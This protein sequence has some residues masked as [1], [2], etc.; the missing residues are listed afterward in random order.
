MALSIQDLA[1]SWPI[2]GHDRALQM[3]SRSIAWDRVSH[4]Y[5]FTGPAQVG[6]RA[7]A[8]AFAMALNCQAEPPDGCAVP[9]AP[10]GLCPSCGRILR[11]EHPDVIEVNLATQAAAQAEESGKKSATAKELKID[12]I[13][14]MQHTVGLSPYMGGWKV[15]II[16]DADKLNEEASNALLKTLEEPPAQTVLLLLAPDDSSVLPTIS[17]RCVQVALRPLSRSLVARS[18]VSRWGADPEQAEKLAALSGG[19][20]GWAVSMLRDKNGMERRNRVLEDLALLSG[21]TVVDR[22]NA[23]TKMAKQFTDARPDL[24]TAL[25]IWEGWWRDLLMV[26]SGTPEL[27]M[28]MDQLSTLN[29]L[30]RRVTPENAHSVIASI[31]RTRQQLF[32]NVNP[33]LALESLTLSLP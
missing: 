4:A 26:A 22:I 27:V 9:V 6:K 7:T 25:D 17:S 30:A 11:G 14:E 8:L 31:Q 1:G 15:Y 32:E 29:S 19:R 3:L 2:V 5:L 13:R 10:C 18:L 28:N 23:A 20:V 24:Y 21:S 16:G 33:R 12:T